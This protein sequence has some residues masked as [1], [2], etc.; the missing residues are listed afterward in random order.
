MKKNRRSNYDE[1][2]NDKNQDLNEKDNDKDNKSKN[3][4]NKQTNTIESVKAVGFDNNQLIPDED[5]N[6]SRFFTLKKY[7][8]ILLL[9]LI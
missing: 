3:Q 4:N 5:K 8:F 2:K 1:N 9:V 7:G 6:D